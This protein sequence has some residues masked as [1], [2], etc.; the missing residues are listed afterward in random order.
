MKLNETFELYRN[1]PTEKNLS[2][3][4][5]KS[6]NLI[7]SIVMNIVKH[8][9]D[10]EDVTQEVLIKV[11]Q[12]SNILPKDIN[13]IAWL[14]KVSLN[15]AINS[16]HQ[17]KRAKALV[18]NLQ[19][20]LNNSSSDQKDET[21]SIVFQH[22]SKLADDEQA[23]VI[24][25]HIHQMTFAQLSSLYNVPIP[26]IQSRINVILNKLKV[27]I[28]KAGFAGVALGLISTLSEL[29]AFELNKDLSAS[30]KIHF[31]TKSSAETSPFL[32][33]VKTKPLIASIAIFVTLVVFSSYYFLN[34][35]KNEFTTGIKKN[36]I[37][38]KNEKYLKQAQ[39][40]SDLSANKS[41][42]KTEAQPTEKQSQNTEQNPNSIDAKIQEKETTGFAG[43]L[44]DATTKEPIPDAK[45]EVWDIYTY[46]KIDLKTDEE[47]KYNI[48]DNLDKTFFYYLK[49]IKEGYVAKQTFQHFS[50]QKNISIFMEK[51][52]KIKC[53]LDFYRP[54]NGELYFGSHFSLDGEKHLSNNQKQNLI[55]VFHCILENAPLEMYSI[56]TVKLSTAKEYDVSMSILDSPTSSFFY[57][58]PDFYFYNFALW[59]EDSVKIGS[60]GIKDKGATF[61]QD[62]S[63]NQYALTFKKTG[64]P[65][66]VSELQ[67]YDK[68]TKKERVMDNKNLTRKDE[69]HGSLFQTLI[70]HKGNEYYSQLG[71]RNFGLPDG[72]LA[73]LELLPY[74]TVLFEPLGFSSKYNNVQVLYGENVFSKKSTFRKTT[75]Y[76]G[77]LKIFDMFFEEKLLET[78]IVCP[79]G[80]TIDVNAELN[81][82]EKFTKP[83]KVSI[84]VDNK[85]LANAFINL[86]FS[87]LSKDDPNSYNH[88]LQLDEM[89]ASNIKIKSNIKFISFNFVKD[90]AAYSIQVDL[91]KITNDSINLEFNKKLT[92]NLPEDTL[93]SYLKA[94][95]FNLGFIDPYFSSTGSYINITNNSALITVPLSEKKVFIDKNAEYKVTDPGYSIK[96]P[97]NQLKALQTIAIDE[98]TETIEF[99]N[100]TEFDYT[101]VNLNI[102]DEN[103]EPLQNSLW[104]IEENSGNAQYTRADDF[105]CRIEYFPPDEEIFKIDEKDIGKL[106]SIGED[107]LKN[108]TVQLL[109]NRT[110]SLRVEMPNYVSVNEP[111]VTNSTGDIYK[112][113]ILYKPNS[114]IFNFKLTYELDEIIKKL[115]F[116]DIIYE[117]N[118]IRIL[119]KNMLVK[120]QKDCA[121][122]N[123][124]VK[125]IRD[126]TPMTVTIPS[127]Q[128]FGIEDYFFDDKSG[129]PKT[130]APK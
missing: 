43:V 123:I 122:E 75:N 81:S 88:R 105:S 93:A 8:N 59:Y 47:G 97:F 20:N 96:T 86:T 73:K 78:N 7:F 55:N 41:E 52:K 6:Q 26:T 117:Y 68:R 126:N 125:L 130:D 101:N 84:S 64:K 116:G 72:E 91:L 83:L 48:P 22:L 31:P 94:K 128:L 107:N 110:Y 65:V 102:C 40:N 3:V 58:N 23:M 69:Y 99:K 95:Q 74:S 35:Q 115:N 71:G 108:K 38:I 61:S 37:E 17:K 103:G 90:N 56:A 118:G 79:I 54:T 85:P 77:E 89:G 24:N 2:E 60:F 49:F 114:V 129:I 111:F 80:G 120:A 87:N 70:T 62:H 121:L 53:Q 106:I 27:S 4:I 25:K 21:V 14:N 104:S 5:K 10:A 16:Y 15:A 1:N 45:L 42:T 57:Q 33:K 82:S 92:L 44:L 63:K 39:P 113:V 28:E 127:Y 100:V 19:E 9:Q 30:V 119:N 50:S 29:K 66:T 46:Q 13:F 32:T 11:I 34:D 67:V 76:Q 12:N 36:E 109:N 98:K 18:N 124:K 112:K 51:G